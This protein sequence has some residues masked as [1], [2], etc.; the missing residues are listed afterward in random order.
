MAV[1]P[2]ASFVSGFSWLPDFVIKID[3]EPV[4]GGQTTA[5]SFFIRLLIE[6][7]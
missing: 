7:G 4:S 3:G 6:Y 2:S 1:R 5:K